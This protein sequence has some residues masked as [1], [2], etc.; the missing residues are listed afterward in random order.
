MNC[1]ETKHELPGF[2]FGE[3][4]VATRGEVEAHVVTC[5]S[6]VS[7]LVA[8]KRNADATKHR[9]EALKLDPESAEAKA[10]KVP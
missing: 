6:C 7:E 1:D 3:L 5:L 8:L 9:D 4:S 2:H 10:V